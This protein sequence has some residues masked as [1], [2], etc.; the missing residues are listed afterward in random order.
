M[1]RRFLLALML[2]AT[3]V[4]AEAGFYTD[5]WLKLSEPG[6]GANLV[7]TDNFIFATFFIYGPSGAP[8][9][10]TAELNWNGVDRYAGDLFAN[11][12][13]FFGVPWVGTTQTTVGTAW[14]MPSAVNAY[15]GT[16]YYTHTG[17][18][19]AT[20]AIERQNLARPGLGGTYSGGQV[21]V[22]T[23]CTNP[24]NNGAFKDYYDLTVTHLANNTATFKFI[25]LDGL[26]CTLSGALIQNGLLYRAPTV[27]YVCTDATGTV[28][29]TTATLSEIKATSQGIEGRY[30][31][32]HSFG[33]CGETGGFSAAQR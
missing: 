21:G 33:G 26:T 9:W 18:G 24:A 3:A 31:A 1:I 16:L 4:R 20:N 6:W 32:P 23:G 15:Q 10:Y 29:N 2:L 22:F 14:F 19:S 28:L 5:I 30:S 27:T 17:V 12:G 7:Q 25:N 8:T 13:T 11:Q